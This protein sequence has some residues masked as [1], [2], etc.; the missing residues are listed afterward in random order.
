MPDLT[1]VL[2]GAGKSTRFGCKTKK[3]W[4][5]VGDEP[6]W[7]YLA[8]RLEEIIKNIKIIIVSD[9]AE[10][11]YMKN[12]A[13]YSFVKGGNERQESLVNALREVDS[14]FVLVTDIARACIDKRVIKELIEKRDK[15][16]VIV[17][18]IGIN[19]TVHFNGSPIDR[20]GIKLI[21]TPQLSKTKVLK[22]ALTKEKLY[23]DESSAIID[24]GGSI[25][26]IEGSKSAHKLT[27]FED[28]KHLDC[29][30]PPSRE[31]FIGFGYDVHPFEKGKKMFLGGVKIEFDRGFKAHSDGDV[32][33]HALIDSLLGAIGAGDIGE[34]FPDSDDNYKDIDSKILLQKV[35]T[36]ISEVGYDIINCD[37]T[38]C[39]EI[40]KISPHKEK[41][42]KT[43]SDILSMS[44]QKI[45]I[46]ATTT[47]K[48]GFVGREEGVG[49]YATSLLKYSDWTKEADK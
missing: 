1:L 48:L 43:I 21:Q 36:F 23:T 2:L 13:P 42:R 41:M 22:Q 37:I 8:K 44:A 40:P 30:T 31:S 6:L 32:A 47:E 46:K 34:I 15:A 4:I 25:Y 39:A 27:Y 11:K 26:Y 5:R 38:I 35:A 29:L 9:E 17:P 19:D 12:Y 45:N 28:L 49:V 16:D 24:N 33:L 3:Q 7:L 10:I 20:K 14:E 18:Y